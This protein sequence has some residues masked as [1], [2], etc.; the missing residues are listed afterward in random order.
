MFFLSLISIR[1]SLSQINDVTVWVGA[2]NPAL[3]APF[4]LNA[5]M[6]RRISKVVI[7]GQYNALTFVSFLYN[8][9]ELLGYSNT[10]FC[11]ILILLGK[12]YSHYYTGHTC[13]FFA[14][15]FTCLFGT[16]I[17]RN[18]PIRRQKSCYYGMGT[19]W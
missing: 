5:P 9:K 17:Y 8:G 1:L 3:P 12:W 7:H 14:N 2:M 4:A 15:C 19:S 13:R 11:N 18:W 16:S 10:F 6:T